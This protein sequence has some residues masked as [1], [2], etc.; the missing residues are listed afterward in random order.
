MGKVRAALVLALVA[1]LGV[2]GCDLRT[3]TPTPSP[4]EPTTLESLR[5]EQAAHAQGLLE[6]AEQVMKALPYS[7]DARPVVEQVVAGATAHVAALGPVYDS[8]MPEHLAPPQPT[9]PEYSGT[10]VATLV[11]ALTAEHALAFDVAIT[12]E[13]PQFRSLM[14]SI[15]LWRAVIVEQLCKAANITSPGLVSTAWASLAADIDDPAALVTAL[16]SLGYGFEVYAARTSDEERARAESAAA[17]MRHLAQEVAVANEVGARIPDTRLAAYPLP[18]IDFGDPEAAHAQVATWYA[19]LVVL[20]KS[21][22]N[23]AQA[24]RGWLIS[25]AAWALSEELSWSG[26]QVPALP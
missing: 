18:D 1:L 26:G 2:T 25:L 20:A 21:Q 9:A 8:G 7:H 19:D 24:A 5:D 11:D 12:T 13:D 6:L 14:T 17:A 23:D 3:E 16:D 4:L 10:S 15:T 22:V